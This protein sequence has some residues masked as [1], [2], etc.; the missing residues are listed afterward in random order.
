MD[1][2]K[3]KTVNKI[4]LW[5]L[6]GLVLA[7]LLVLNVMQNVAHLRVL[8]IAALVVTLCWMIVFAILEAKARHRS[9]GSASPTTRTRQTGQT[10]PKD[11]TSPSLP[12]TQ[13]TE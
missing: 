10:C 2:K 7:L 8:V 9:H 11:S 13:A 1:L 4:G 5:V 6:A 12:S 3:V